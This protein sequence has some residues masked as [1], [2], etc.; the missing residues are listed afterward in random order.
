MNFFLKTV[1]TLLQMNKIDLI[2]KKGKTF[3]NY[4]LV[5]FCKAS[6]LPVISLFRLNL[7]LRENKMWFH[8]MILSR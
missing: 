2:S 7:S 6:C 3:I 5:N 4:I 1:E 8:K